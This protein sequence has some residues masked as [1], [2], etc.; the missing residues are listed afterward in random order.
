[1]ADASLAS[2]FY[3]LRVYFFFAGGAFSSY[4]SP[5]YASD[6]GPCSAADGPIIS[7]FA[8]TDFSTLLLSSLSLM[9]MNSI[10]YSAEL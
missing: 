4:F 9:F 7:L 5:I 3:F 10:F 8:S 6:V 2:L 1:V